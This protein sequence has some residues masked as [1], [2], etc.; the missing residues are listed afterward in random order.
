MDHVTFSLKSATPSGLC[1]E[2][3]AAGPGQLLQQLMMPHCLKWDYVIVRYICPLKRGH[4]Q[5][6]GF[7]SN[8]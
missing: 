1:P 2:G 8:D 4:V 6:L 7:P 5:I 3:L